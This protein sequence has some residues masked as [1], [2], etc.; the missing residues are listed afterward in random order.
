MKL[1]S[2]EL[3]IVTFSSWGCVEKPKNRVTVQGLRQDV[4]G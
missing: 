2:W 3:D 1:S 4:E